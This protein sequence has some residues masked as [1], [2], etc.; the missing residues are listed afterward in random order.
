MSLFR[1]SYKGF[2]CRHNWHGSDSS[3]HHIYG[4]ITDFSGNKIVDNYYFG[5]HLTYD[6][7]VT[8]FKNYI[9][10]LS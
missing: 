5:Q 4:S 10:S 2:I 8:K 7:F 1:E 9:D 6:E 3:N